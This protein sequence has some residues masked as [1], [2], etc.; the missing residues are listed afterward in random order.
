M[1][2]SRPRALSLK[3]DPPLEPDSEPD[4]DLGPYA[5]SQV[6]N[7]EK[8][9]S[10][11]PEWKHSSYK[12][13]PPIERRQLFLE[14]KSTGQGW[15]TL[16]L[17]LFE[18]TESPQFPL[19]DITPPPP[20][21]YELRVIVWEAEKLRYD[22]LEVFTKDD[23][24]DFYVHCF[25]EEAHAEDSKRLSTDTHFRS[26][27]GKASWNY[28]LK[29][30]M[31][32]KPRSSY[33]R[34]HFELWDKDIFSA[35]DPAVRQR[36][37]EPYATTVPSSRR[38]RA[39][40]TPRLCRRRSPASRCSPRQPRCARIPPLASAGPHPTRVLPSV[41]LSLPESRW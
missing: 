19:L 1:T 9:E 36:R 8:G 38:D 10:D 22:G 27:G 16:F 7:P 25:V 23:I 14:R 15:V 26:R 13:K 40:V 17:E 12:R 39:V 6:I 32:L 20:Q 33:T 37:I 24:A 30:P 21:N 34:I 31:T 11:W 35:D 3:L 41:W 29:F 28:R 5:F 2:L 4:P 18:K